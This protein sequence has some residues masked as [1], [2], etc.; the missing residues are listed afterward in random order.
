M[1][2]GWTTWD[3]RY[4]P[5]DEITHQHLSNIYYYT[6][7]VLAKWYD[8]ET[9]REVYHMLMTKFGSILPYRPDIRFI[10]EQVYLTELGYLQNNNDIVID[11]KIVGKYGEVA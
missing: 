8:A 11:G 7:F 2:K 6:H 9:K 1:L 10:Q 5:V 3:N 4:I